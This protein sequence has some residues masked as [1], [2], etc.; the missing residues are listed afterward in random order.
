MGYQIETSEN[1]ALLVLKFLAYSF[2]L[3]LPVRI[4]R[5][6]WSIPHFD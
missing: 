6:T 4:Q 3:H 5:G 2:S 1:L